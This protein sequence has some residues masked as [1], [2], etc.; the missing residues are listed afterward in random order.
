MMGRVK[1]EEE[2]ENAAEEDKSGKDDEDEES[3]NDEEENEGADDDKGND[4]A[5][6][7][8]RWI[9]EFTASGLIFDEDHEGGQLH[10]TINLTH[11]DGFADLTSE[12]LEISSVLGAEGTGH[13]GVVI[14]LRRGTE[15]SGST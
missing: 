13:I 6:G 7:Q 12:S 2:E 14:R 10:C 1:S 5:A 4:G 3:D 9:L 15:G 11:L 8:A